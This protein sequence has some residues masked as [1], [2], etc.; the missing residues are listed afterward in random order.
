MTQRLVG[1]HAVVIGGSMAGLMAA[2]VLSDHFEHVTLIE[3]DTLH[4][5]PQARKGQPQARHV[6]GLLAR[7]LEVANQYFPDLT[8]GLQAGGAIVGEMSARM[9]WHIAG[10]YRMRYHSGLTGV[11]L[12]RPFLEW[13]IRQRVVA[14]PNVTVLHQC[15]VEQLLTTGERTG[16]TGV[17][18][19]RHPADGH[20]E[21]IAA[22]LVVDAAGR[23]SHTP[24]WLAS[25]GY[26]RPTEQ[27]IKIGVGY[28][29]RMYRRRADDAPDADA[30]VV[31]A[32]PPHGKRSGLA[33]AV[34]GDRWQVALGGI[35][36]DYPPTDDAG[37]LAWARSLPAPDVY[38]LISRLEPLGP[39]VMHKFPSSLRRHYEKLARFPNGYLVLGDAV[40]SFNPTYG[41]GMTSTILQAAALDDA[42]RQHGVE[43]GLAKCFFTEA[44]KIIDIPWQQ[45]A[46]ADFSYPETEG[47]KARGTDLINAYVA[48]VQRATH[49]DPVVYG[50]FLRVM[51]LM[52][53]PSTLF[54]PNILVRVLASSLRKQ[55]GGATTMAK[56]PQQSQSIMSK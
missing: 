25:L 40:C 37:F 36:N 50:A 27:I 14:L 52:A 45:A 15:S 43:P 12:T 23:G 33:F 28:A 9:R 47:H 56:E 42:L 53:T 34:E 30:V 1:T 19:V 39:I 20:T 41:Q 24:Q 32:N 2:R 10:G 35:A 38:D 3:R 13:Q 26:A 8:D 21:Q 48:R 11:L 7:G 18:V 17:C 16:V 46:G 6:H 5:E 44:A 55:K 49:H 4:D 51:N 29:S 31:S 54:A 22:D